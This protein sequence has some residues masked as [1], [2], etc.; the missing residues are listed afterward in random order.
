MRQGCRRVACFE[1]A[2]KINPTHDG[3]WNGLGAV[4]GGKVAGIAYSKVAC[5][6]EAL[7]IN[8]TNLTPGSMWALRV[9]GRLQA[10]PAAR[11]PARKRHGSSIPLVVQ[12]GRGGE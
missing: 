7:K 6:Q 3:G 9:E 11:P 10:K 2:L 8:S 1:E 12:R 5:F 4:G